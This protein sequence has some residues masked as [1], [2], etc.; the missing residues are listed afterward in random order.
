MFNLITF[1]VI[2][3]LLNFILKIENSYTILGLIFNHKAM[4]KEEITSYA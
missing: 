4:M 2:K 3:R 1:K